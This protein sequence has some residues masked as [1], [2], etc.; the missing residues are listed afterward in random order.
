VNWWEKLGYKYLCTDREGYLV[1]R[2]PNGKIETL[3]EPMTWRERAWLEDA[4][5]RAQD[6]CVKR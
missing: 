1:L 3:P 4:R 2:N 6:D 5:R